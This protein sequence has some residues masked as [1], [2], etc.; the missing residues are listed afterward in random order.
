MSALG[1]AAED[2]A[3]ALSDLLTQDARLEVGMQRCLREGR[4]GGREGG[5]EGER[6]EANSQRTTLARQRTRAQGGA[7]RPGGGVHDLHEGTARTSLKLFWFMS[8]AL[9]GVSGVSL[10]SLA[11]HLARYL[12]APSSAP[13]FDPCPVC[14]AIPFSLDEWH[15]PSILLGICIGVWVLRSWR[16]CFASAWPS[17]A[18]C[19]EEVGLLSFTASCSV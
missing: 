2:F 17:S 5:K 7:L 16:L 3:Q 19:S 14:P 6:F 1:I 12:E 18:G 9:V 8:R 10:T 11:L 15:L 4:G 13:L